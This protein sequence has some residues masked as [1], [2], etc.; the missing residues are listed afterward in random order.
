MYKYGISYYTIEEG[1][2]VP[3]TGVDIRLVSPGQSWGDGFALIETETSGYYECQIEHENECGYYEVW[4]DRSGSGA[5]TGKTC[6][7]GKMNAK[8]IQNNSIFGNHVVDGAITGTKIG[9]GSVGKNHLA[10]QVLTLA[11]MQYETQDETKGVGDVTSTSPATPDDEYITHILGN[12]YAAIPMVLLTVRCNCHIYIY[13]VQ[14]E[15]TKIT[16]R[17]RIG[18]IHEVEELSYLLIAFQ[19]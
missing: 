3:L 18:K 1:E 14:K 2:R 17:L 4:D 9:N 6:I 10:D 16:V 15:D 8:G 13:D 12:E 5:F 7:I 11:K 19:V